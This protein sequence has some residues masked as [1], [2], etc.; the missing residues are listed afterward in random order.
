MFPLIVGFSTKASES[1]EARRA[2]DN[3]QKAVVR[4]P[5]VESRTKIGENPMGPATPPRIQRGEGAIGMASRLTSP[6]DS[7]CL[8]PSFPAPTQLVFVW[9]RFSSLQQSTSRIPAYW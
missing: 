3:R 6:K 2:S 4:G 9:S 5:T 8:T 1:G 7:F